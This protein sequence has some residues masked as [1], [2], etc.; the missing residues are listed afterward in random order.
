[1]DPSW[2]GESLNMKDWLIPDLN[3]KG[4]N[5]WTLTQIY[6]RNKI[7]PATGWGPPVISGFINHEITPINYSNIYHKATYKAT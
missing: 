1:M 3:M 2:V 7:E 5:G 4:L 6:P